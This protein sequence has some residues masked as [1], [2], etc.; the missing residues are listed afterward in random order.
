MKKAAAEMMMFP[1]ISKE[2]GSSEVEE[3]GG[4]RAVRKK[5]Q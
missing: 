2:E 1:S 3:D 5:G 4:L